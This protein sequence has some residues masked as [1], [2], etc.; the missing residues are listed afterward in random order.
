[1]P[2]PFREEQVRYTTCPYNCWPI[3]CGL[4]VTTRDDG[5]LQIAGNPSHDFSRGML[6]VKGQSAGEIAHSPARIKTPLIREGE[7]G[8]GGWRPATWDEALGRIATRIE[9]NIA[10]GRREANAIYHSHGNIVHRVNWKILTPRFA[11]LAGITLWDG[12]FPCWYDV[13]LAQKLSGFWG[14]HDPVETGDHAGALVNWA[15]DPCASQ[16]NMVPY[17]ARIRDR[18]GLVV[19]ID[20]RITQTAA[21]RMECSHHTTDYKAKTNH[22]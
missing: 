1:M 9:A 21:I 7:R 12:N 4:A 13:G 20:P 11:N 17:L 10:A 14:L 18:G 6:C 15:Q 3:N 16:A 8:A 2:G 5:S 19:T 22:H